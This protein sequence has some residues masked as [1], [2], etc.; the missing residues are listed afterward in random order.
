MKNKLSYIINWLNKLNKFLLSYF[1]INL[2]NKPFIIQLKAKAFIMMNIL[3]LLLNLLYILIAYFAKLELDFIHHIAIFII[4][5]TSL[6]IVRK[7]NFEKAANLF[8]LSL[9]LLFILTINVFSTNNSFE[10]F[11]DEFYFL[12]AFMVLS[13]LFTSD[14][15]ILINSAI[16]FSGT[17]LFFIFR[18][19]H[20]TEISKDAI[21]NFEFVLIIVT[22][23]LL[24][25]ST[26][27]RKTIAFAEDKANDFFKQKDD[28][29]HAL[30]TIA[31][32]SDAMLKMSNKIASFTDNLNNS[33]NIQADSV[34]QMYSNISSLSDSITSNAK[35]SELALNTTSERV[36]VVR[37][38]TRLLKRVISTVRDISKRINVIEEI[39]RQTNFLALN[40]AIEAARA[41]NAG[42]GFSVVAAEVKKLAEISQISAKDII[43]LVNEGISVSDQAW[44]YLGAIVENSEES[45]TLI[46]KITDALNEQ[47]NNIEH[48]K[49]G[50]H[51]I[52][53]AAQTNAG[54]ADSLVNQ[55]D[56]MKEVS[57]LQ[58]E[59][60]KDQLD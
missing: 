49:D 20:S 27:I 32:T 2:Q 31:A 56:D 28:T 46:I 55:T 54:I 22:G 13:L 33:T 18:T 4:I 37:R 9:I 15:M 39:A 11:I 21:I 6:I 5:T 10:Q 30:M 51:E 35:Y 44:D 41:G 45:R 43:S 34:E 8:I 57:N 60:F 23:I 7:G 25:I 52:N 1:L 42:K 29:T 58:Q 26:I 40:A 12:L 59:M 14:K 17:L 47:K 48:I 3:A 36:M 16:I 24:I 19:N 50:M 38:S 53:N